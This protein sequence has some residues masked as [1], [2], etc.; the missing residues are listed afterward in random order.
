[1]LFFSQ[2]G[3]KIDWFHFL[4]LKEHMNF[5]FSGLTVD[6]DGMKTLNLAYGDF[7]IPLINALQEQQRKIL[8]QDEKLEKLEKMVEAILLKDGSVE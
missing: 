7:V 1:V 6:D 3:K 4:F 8:S 5:E 2:L